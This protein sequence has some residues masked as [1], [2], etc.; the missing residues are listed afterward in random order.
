MKNVLITGAGRGIGLALAKEFAHHGYRVLGTYRNESSA[1][2]LM[3]LA[4]ANSAVI[5]IKADVKD[6]KTFEAL[7]EELKKIG[8]L[9]IL[10][11]NA[12]VIGEKARSL[13]ELN[14]SA[15]TGVFETNTFGPMRV[16]QLAI[17]FMK[18]GGTIAQITSRMGSIADNT[19]GGN[20]DYRMSKAALNMFNMCLAK[21]FPQIV[22]LALHPGWVQTEMGGP[23]A[24]VTVEACARG[25]FQ[26]ITEATSEQSG[27][28]F[29]YTGASIPW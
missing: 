14:I 7:K 12:G 19:S 6:E 16:A 1:S 29:D 28:F 8:T 13:L 3:Q 11:N 26:R 23:G 20:Y 10:I 2:G 4:G 22:C 27:Q 21:E 5:P 18:S 15:I 17:P 24:S 9:D 25:L